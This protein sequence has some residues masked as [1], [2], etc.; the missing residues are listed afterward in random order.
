MA[1]FRQLKSGKWQ[2]RVF[3]NG[4]HESVGTF[5]TKKE[6]EIKAGE[7]EKHIYYNETLTDRNILFQDVIDD[8]FEIKYRN[9]KGPTF[10]QLEVIKRRH[11][12]PY[13]GGQTKTFQI[14]RQDIKDWMDEYEMKRDK[15]GNPQYS[16]GSRLRYLIVLK[17]IFNHAVYE[18]EILN[19]NP[20]ARLKLPTRG[21]V[22]IKNEVK[23]YNLSEIDMLLEY[24]GKY[25]RPSR[26]P[27]YQVYYVLIYFLSRTGLRISEAL[28]LRWSDINGNR[29]NIERQTSRNDN[30][31]LTVTTLKTVSSYRNIEIDEETIKLLAWFRKK[32]QK[33]IMKH[34]S[35]KRNKDMIIFQTYR[36]DYM[37]P[38]T[39]R[40]TLERQCLNAGVEYKG[41]HAFRH[42]H[43]VL[44][45]EAGA[46]LIYI[47]RRLGHGSIQTTADTYLD[48]TPQYESGELNKISSYLNSN[49]AQTWH[50]EIN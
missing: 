21:N 37:T 38:S 48:I 11:I 28:A 8:W 40:D 2:A 15:D 42:T 14:S 35:F 49:V 6:A 50:E 17:E 36:G 19:K 13:F 43:A 44:S 26:Y 20:S 4:K 22:S 47:S 34:D 12:E 18:M 5:N 41:T 32:Q 7:A 23:Y 3:K 24:L 31:K 33:M 1:T 30:N 46:D 39:V 9:V 45:L 25:Y 16:F 10:E 29:L 27:E